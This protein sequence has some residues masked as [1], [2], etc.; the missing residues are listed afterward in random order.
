MAAHDSHSYP[1]RSRARWLLVVSLTLL[2]AC[3]SAPTLPGACQPIAPRTTPSGTLPG[4]H[5]VKEIDGTWQV[6]WSTGVEQVTQVV[7]TIGKAHAPAG[8]DPDA[9]PNAM[10]RGRPASVIPIGDAPISQIAIVW[11]VGDCEYTMWVG[12]GLSVEDAMAYAGRY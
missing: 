10:V 4:P 5:G 11:S 8:L 6:T 12:P 2:S 7:G 1:I 9:A 3:A